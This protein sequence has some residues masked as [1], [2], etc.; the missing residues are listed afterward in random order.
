MMASSFSAFPP[1]GASPR[2]SYSESDFK[3]ECEALVR[4]YFTHGILVEVE[5]SLK[6]LLG[7]YA[8]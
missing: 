4:E 8:S 6:E 5:D 2:A 3:R 1:L 7:R